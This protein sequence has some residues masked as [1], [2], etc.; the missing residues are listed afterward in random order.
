MKKLKLLPLNIGPDSPLMQINSLITEDKYAY[1]VD[2]IT[3][4]RIAGVK[5]PVSDYAISF[6]RVF[7][8]CVESEEFRKLF[9]QTLSNLE[10]HGKSTSSNY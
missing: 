5:D 3:D 2:L 1:F 6:R 9:I 10:N 7:F 8:E 4:A